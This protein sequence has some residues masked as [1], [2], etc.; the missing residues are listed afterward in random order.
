MPSGENNRKLSDPQL[1]EIIRLYV[2]EHKSAPYIA[3]LFG[4]RPSAIDHHLKKRGVIKRTNSEAHL[5][6]NSK[7]VTRLPYGDPPFCKCGCAQHV[8]WN[9]RKD[10]WYK[11]VRG[12]YRQESPYKNREWLNAQYV[13]AHRSIDEISET[14]NVSQS[15]IRKSMLRL[16]IVTRS[17]SESLSQRGTMRGPRNPAWKGGVAKWEYSHDWK[18]IARA[19]RKRDN[20]TCQKCE[21]PF[22]KSS[23][24]LHVHHLDGKKFNNSDSNLI[25]LCASCHP[26]G[27][28]KEKAFRL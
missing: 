6:W 27:K 24:L 3:C 10:Q 21:T 13:T 18:K 23:K 28:R 26:K 5:G 11:F 9:Q 8:S 16:G 4:V 17:V 14:C 25:T 22:P 7:P 15:S 12:H 1:N 19:I 20:Y 2:S